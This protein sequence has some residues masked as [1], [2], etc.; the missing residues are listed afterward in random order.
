MRRRQAEGVV[1][2]CRALGPRLE[3]MG[4]IPGYVGG[5]VF[6][7]ASFV[8]AYIPVLLTA[9]AAPFFVLYQYLL[10]MLPLV[11]YISDIFCARCAC[12]LIRLI[13]SPTLPL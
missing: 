1:G 7:R 2:P 13:L 8:C 6:V 3:G 9:A 12:V 11:L 4:A 10:S 5:Y